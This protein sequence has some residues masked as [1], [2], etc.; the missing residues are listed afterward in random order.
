MTVRQWAYIGGVIVVGIALSLATFLFSSLPMS[1][2]FIFCVLTIFAT[3]AQFIEFPFSDNSQA[4]YPHTI[5]FFAGLLL[6]SPL[7]FVLLVAI[8]HVAEMLKAYIERKRLPFSWHVQLFNI[9]L[10]IIVGL[11]A[12]WVYSVLYTDTLKLLPVGSFVVATLA[13]LSYVA[14]NH[15]LVGFA[16]VIVG[17]MTWRESGIWAVENLVT[18]FILL[19]MGYAVAVL[20]G[21]NPWLIIPALAPLV[22]MYRALL[23]PKLTQEAQT[24]SKTGLLNARYFNQRFAEELENARRLH[25]PLALLMADLDLL[26]VINNTYGHLGGDAVLAGVG[27]IIHASISDHELAGRFGGEEF[28]IVLPGVDQEEARTLAERIRAKIEA[29]GF[30]SATTPNPICATM[31]FG[32]ACFPA[33]ADTMNNL[34]HQADVAVYHAKLLGR[35][36]VMCLADLPQAIRFEGIPKN[37]L[38]VLPAETRAIGA[39]ERLRMDSHS[40]SYPMPPLQNISEPSAP[41]M[42]PNIWRHIFMISV[43]IGGAIVA[44]GGLY[45]RP[46]KDWIAIGLLVIMAIIAELLQ[47]DLYRIG[48]ISASVTFAFAAALLIGIPGVVFVSAAIAITTAIVHSQQRSLS[49]IVFKAAFNWA[50]HLLAGTVPIVILRVLGLPLEIKYLA[51]LVFAMGFAAILYFLVESGLVATVIGLSSGVPIFR[52]WKVQFRWLTGHYLVLCIMGLFFSVAYRTFDWPGMIVFVLPILMMRYSQMQYVEQTEDNLHELKRLNQELARANQ[53]VISANNAVLQLNNE[54]FMTLAQIIDARDP[55]VSCHAA[56]VADYA[57]VV[58]KE[59]RLPAEQVEQIRQAALL[60]DIGKIAISEAVLQKTERLTE[61]EY[62]YIKTHATIGAAFLETSHGLR[63]L[64]GFVRHHH[65]WW[66]GQGYPDKLRGEEIPFESRILAVC[67]TVEVM[68]SDRA[69]RKALSLDQIIDELR[70]MQGTQFDPI[71]A[72]IFAR[73]LEREGDR[74]V[75]NSSHDVAKHALRWHTGWPRAMEPFNGVNGDATRI[76]SMPEVHAPQR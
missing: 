38:A 15:F 20:W 54:L 26:R 53:G 44:V 63:H 45:F 12:Q 51:P 69:Y 28:A 18:D 57:V 43:I 71:I 60:H 19:Y 31:S 17:D 50:T 49:G 25:E 55:Y 23:V 40:T 48:T 73:I 3:L 52:T 13:A 76:F 9:S 14:M 36:R 30:V 68:A 5:F 72:E 1:Q 74:L 24:D 66:N 70:R 7:F 41:H 33:D 32:I 67:D 8:P 29:A 2:W 42:T 22:L 64:A 4:Y 62:E 61:A 6:L 39:T 35:N 75:V 21:V 47:V 34:L 59:M 46:E 37:G 27:R 56:K 10:H 65:E 16:M 58:A 11:M